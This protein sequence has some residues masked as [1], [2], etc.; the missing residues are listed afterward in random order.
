MGRATIINYS[1]P[2]NFLESI[3]K[4]EDL[5]N[6]DKSFLESVESLP[7]RYKKQTTQN[8]LKSVKFRYLVA[9]Y[10]RHCQAKLLKEKKENIK[11]KNV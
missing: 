6:K 8:K 4:A 3:Q 7:A 2:A 1:V 10:I 11:E 9:F 5:L